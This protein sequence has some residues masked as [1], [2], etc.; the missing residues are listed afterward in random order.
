MAKDFWFS[1]SV[2]ETELRDSSMA[3]KMD[4]SL[5][6]MPVVALGTPFSGWAVCTPFWNFRFDLALLTL[7]NLCEAFLILAGEA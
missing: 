6:L 4:F 2:T 5:F 1:S 3:K 7:R